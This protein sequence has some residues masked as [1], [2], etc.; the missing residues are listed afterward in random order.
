M[1]GTQ[2]EGRK[3]KE[4]RGR[5]GGWGGGG[6]EEKWKKKMKKMADQVTCSSI[7]VSAQTRG[8]KPP[9]P[10]PPSVSRVSTC[11]RK[12]CLTLFVPVS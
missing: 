2:W 10:P 9:S 4:G 1:E 7:C 5:G 8:G 11:Y 12:V 6:G 3:Q